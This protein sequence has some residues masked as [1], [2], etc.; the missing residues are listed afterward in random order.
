MVRKLYNPLFKSEEESGERN[1]FIFFGILVA[2]ILID[3]AILVL[4]DYSIDINDQLDNADEWE[5]KFS[6]LTLTSNSEVLISD[7]N[8]EIVTFEVPSNFSDDGWM[9]QEISIVITYSETSFGD[10]DCDTVTAEFEHD[11]KTGVS[12]VSEQT[13]GESSDCT[14]IQMNKAWMYFTDGVYQ[15]I[16]KSD[17]ENILAMEEV[18]IDVL[19][20]IRV[21]TDSTIPNNDDDENISV[22]FTITLQKIESITR[23]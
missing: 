10:V 7:N 2:V 12:S 19:A 21:N 16:S 13:S 23:V 1:Q 20:Y 9:V 3:S 22:D 6:N 4:G 18:G 5:I 17:A 14:E 15:D 11:E 8:E